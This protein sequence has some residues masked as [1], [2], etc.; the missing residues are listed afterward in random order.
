[1]PAPK[2]MGLDRIRDRESLVS[3]ESEAG[4]GWPGR[5]TTARFSAYN[6]KHAPG[7]GS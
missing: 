1:M 5:T 6:S 4:S 2:M 3:R 7:S